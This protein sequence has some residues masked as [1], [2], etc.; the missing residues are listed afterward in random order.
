MGADAAGSLRAE[1]VQVARNSIFLGIGRFFGLAFGFAT[2]I[3]VT[4]HLGDAYGLWIGAQRFTGLFLLLVYFGLQPLM[5]RAIATRREDVGGL[6]GTVL[7]LR[8]GLGAV[9]A[10]LVLLVSVGI[11]YLPEYRWLLVAFVVIELL[12]ALAEAWIAVCDGLER[13]GRAAAVTLVRPL[14]TFAAVLV[15]LALEGGLR[16]VAIAYVTSQVA[17]LAAAALMARATATGLRLRVHPQRVA[18]LLREGLVFLAVGVAFMALRSLDV[19]MLTRLASVPEVARYGAALNFLELPRELPMLAQRALLP[20]FSRLA[21][22]TR[23]PEI[24]RYA[25][26][27]FALVLLPMGA[28]LALAADQVV[29]LYPSGEFADAAPVLRILAI[30]VPL[31]G[32]TSVCAIF[33]TGLGRLDRV[34]AAYALAIPVEVAVNALLIPAYAALGVAAGIVAGFAVLSLGLVVASRGFGLRMPGAALGRG[35]AATGVMALALLPIR[36]LSLLVVVPAGA[37]AYALALLAI[38][39]RDSIERRLLR[40]A[41]SRLRA[42]RGGV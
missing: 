18:P 2:T 28:G 24:A 13:M 23:A 17:Q 30:S 19:I 4:D 9:A 5:V 36:E 41:A 22:D 1:G 21:A 42:G 20:V 6:V 32:P 40:D 15:V 7:A 35:L 37:A 27:V 12:G 14:V 38:A 29:A 39:P 3:L 16:A 33:L 10:A 11:A 31:L 8:L 25:L 34:L 26:H